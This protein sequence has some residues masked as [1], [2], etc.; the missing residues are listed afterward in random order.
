MSSL[1]SSL[2]DYQVVLMVNPEDVDACNRSLSKFR[3]DHRVD[4]SAVTI[5]PKDSVRA[6]LF[7][8][9][10]LSDADAEF[11]R[12]QLEAL[13]FNESAAVARVGSSGP[14]GAFVSLH[15]PEQGSLSSFV[16][17]VQQA[18]QKAVGGKYQLQPLH[19]GLGRVNNQGAVNQ[20]NFKGH[21]HALPAYT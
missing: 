19:V 16:N 1:V 3:S 17:R 6:N 4:R 20:R 11:L 8:V 13:S 7:T 10:A 5:F 12:R 2:N 18:A 21:A 15:I 9:K 14:N